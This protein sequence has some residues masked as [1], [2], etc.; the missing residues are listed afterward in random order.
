[1]AESMLQDVGVDLFVIWILGSLRGVYFFL[2]SLA[3]CFSLFSFHTSIIIH[4][5]KGSH[6]FLAESM[7][8]D[9]GVDLFVIWI[10][11]SLSIFCVNQ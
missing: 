9:L 2:S 11:G 10:L 6:S 7:L 4:F 5:P 3:A 8:Q 1:M